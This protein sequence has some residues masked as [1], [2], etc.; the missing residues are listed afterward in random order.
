MRRFLLPLLFTAAPIVALAS[1]PQ[2]PRPRLDVAFILDTTGS[3]GDEIDVVKEKLVG[4]A[5]NLRAGQP[6][7]DV[8]YAIV[9]YRDKGDEYVTKSFDFDRDVERVQARVAALDA[10]GGGD[11]PEDIAAAL[12]AAGKLSWDPSPNVSRVAFLVGD[13][14]PHAYPGEPTWQHGLA[15]LRERKVSV[16]TIGCSGLNVEAKSVF[17]A[18]AEKS[19]GHFQTLTYSRVEHL[20]DGRKRTVLMSGDKA[21]VADRELSEADWKRG[22]EELAKE[23]KVRAAPRGEAGRTGGMASAVAAAPAAELRNNLDS[24]IGDRLKKSAEA[25]GATFAH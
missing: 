16:D 14:G 7:P 23:G 15:N 21:Y 4:I 13:A 2:R 3:M 9:A 19:A 20:A 10:G 25:A 8:R 18:I 5:R 22:A 6:A 17:L 1:E 24:E 12:N 11:E